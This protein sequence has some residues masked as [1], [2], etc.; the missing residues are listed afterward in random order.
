MPS[1]AANSFHRGATPIR[2]QGP[3]YRRNSRE[4]PAQ[5]GW[6]AA[7]AAA[8]RRVYGEP[9]EFGRGNDERCIK[10]AIEAL[11]AVVPELSDREAM[12]EAVAAVSYASQTHPKWLYALYSPE[13]DPRW[14]R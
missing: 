11:Y 7:D 12:L 4:I 1:I 5:E 3:G 8:Y 2:S 14:N 9:R 10:A 13:P 6:R